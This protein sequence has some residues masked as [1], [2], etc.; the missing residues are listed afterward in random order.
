M[1]QFHDTSRHVSSLAYHFSHRIG[2]NANCYPKIP[3]LH[4]YLD[5]PKIIF[6]ASSACHFRGVQQVSKPPFHT[7]VQF[8]SV[9]QTPLSQVVYLTS[10]SFAKCK[11]LMLS[12][13]RLQPALETQVNVTRKYFGTLCNVVAIIITLKVLVPKSSEN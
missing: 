3:K 5:V 12:M 11:R 9:H 6:Q 8:C 4:I 2:Y 13:W 1:P 7:L 10:T